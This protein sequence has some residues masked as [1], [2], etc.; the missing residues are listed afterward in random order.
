M[1]MVIVLY[2]SI[3]RVSL[4]FSLFSLSLSFLS[5]SVSVMHPLSFLFFYSVLFVLFCFCN[6]FRCFVNVL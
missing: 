3:L 2:D 5:L 4:S 1:A 6:V